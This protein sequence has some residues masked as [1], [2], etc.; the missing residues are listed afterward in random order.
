[1][2]ITVINIILIILILFIFYIFDCYMIHI[3]KPND[4]NEY[5]IYKKILYSDIEKEIKSGD[6]I[7]F[8]H[9]LA[10]VHERTFGHLQFSHLGIV[11]KMN[12]LLYIYEINSNR[13][14]SDIL[15]NEYDVKLTP[16]YER[17]SNYCGDFFIS[18]LKTKLTKDHEDYLISSIKHKQYKYLPFF[19]IFISFLSNSQK[20]H[21]NDKICSEFIAEILDE[22][23]VTNN[24]NK[25]KKADLMNEIVNLSNGEIYYNPIHIILDELV[26]KDLNS[27]NYKLI[28]PNL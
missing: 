18:S 8:D 7:L 2:S 20:I 11:I 3:K 22:L 26:I 16:L 15:N 23:K 6:L 25:T 28:N 14:Q 24:I 5:K 13:V 27:T 12:S 10:S 19:K 1:M 9:N 17:I 4:C 21:K